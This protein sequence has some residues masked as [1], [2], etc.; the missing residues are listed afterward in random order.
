MVAKL[1]FNFENFF[2]DFYEYG[3]SSLYNSR[4][5][6]RMLYEKYKDSNRPIHL[7]N[8]E[9]AM[10]NYRQKQYKDLEYW[11]KIAI[12]QELIS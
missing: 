5:A 4:D 10:R 8:I 6:S 11:F 12:T 9:L 1:I 3:R 7:E 2:H